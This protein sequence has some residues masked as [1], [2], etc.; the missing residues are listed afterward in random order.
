MLRAVTASTTGNER[1]TAASR[2]NRT[3]IPLKRSAA[4]FS[5]A[6]RVPASGRD[7]RIEARELAKDR[8]ALTLELLRQRVAH[9]ADL[10]RRDDPGKGRGIAQNSKIFTK[11]P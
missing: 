1:Q 4:R 5:A 10:P 11:T 6:P 7:L 8:R 2:S 9:L 3:D